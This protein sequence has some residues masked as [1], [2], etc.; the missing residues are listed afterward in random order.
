[1]KI[2]KYSPI[3]DYEAVLK[4]IISEGEDWSCYS[5]NE[6]KEKYKHALNNSIT[7]V[8]IDDEELCGYSRSIND[9]GFYIHVCDLLVHKDHRGKE[10][11]R[12]LMEILIDEYPDCEIFVMSDVDDYYQKLAY[13]KEG[14][15]FKV[16][17][18]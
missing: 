15:I 9:N 11:G 18:S 10:I 3:K 13:K 16:K 1:M 14:T 7:F 17:P 4:V 12:K 8:A 5:S 2:R 6:S